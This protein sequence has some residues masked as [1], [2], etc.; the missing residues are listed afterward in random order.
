M[1]VI[2]VNSK[3]NVNIRRFYKHVIYR[4]GA[5]KHG[6]VHYFEM[7]LFKTKKNEPKNIDAKRKWKTHENMQRED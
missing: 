2:S 1:F 5:A 4:I 3:L 7:M 6:S